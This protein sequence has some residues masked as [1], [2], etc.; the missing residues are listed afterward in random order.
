MRAAPLPLNERKEN[1][2]GPTCGPGLPSFPTGVGSLECRGNGLRLALSHVPVPA[3]SRGEQFSISREHS[4]KRLLPLAFGPFLAND[5]RALAR[6]RN[7]EE[8]FA[9]G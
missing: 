3:A 4:D 5:S 7:S 8:G 9:T 2:R 6:P 1:G